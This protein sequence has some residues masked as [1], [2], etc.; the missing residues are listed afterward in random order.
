[1]VL[2]KDVTTQ[3]DD[4]GVLLVRVVHMWI[5]PD[6]GNSSESYM[7]DMVLM[8]EEG[9]RIQATIENSHVSNFKDKI[10]EHG[11]Y[12]MMRFEVR[13]NNG[14]YRPTSHSFR[15]YFKENTKIKERE[16]SSETK[17]PK[18]LYSLKSFTEIKK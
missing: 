15:L 4:K 17:F 16:L 7:I 13:A 18:D 1:M 10:K 6:K 2:L 11:L 8:D 9:M 14:D 12:G 3:L 5:V